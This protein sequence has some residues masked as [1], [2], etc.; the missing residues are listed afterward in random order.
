MK[1]T[2]V[3]KKFCAFLLILMWSCLW[4]ISSWAQILS[5]YHIDV[6]QGDATLIISPS[7]KT[8]L[9]D[10]GDTGK[11]ATRVFPLLQALKLD[12]IDYT[13]VTHYDSDHMGGMDEV[14]LA[15]QE[16]VKVNVF[17]RGGTKKSTKAI[18]EYQQMVEDHFKDKHQEIQPGMR[19]DLG[20]EI[21]VV[22]VAVNQ[23]IHSADSGQG[24]GD[25]ENAKSVALVIRYKDFD[26]FIGGDLTG[27][28]KSGSKRTPDMESQVARIVGDID[29]LKINHHGSQTSSNQFF[30]NVL[31]P[32]VAIISVGD[33]GKNRLYHHPH[34]LVLTRLRKLDTLEHIFMTHRGQT[35]GGL[36]KEE[37]KS[38]NIAN[39]NVVVTTNGKSYEVNGVVF[40][41]DGLH[42]LAGGN[43]NGE[44]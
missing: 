5:I 8:L 16:D 12:S 23:K 9:I 17:D 33:G 21:A 36:R 38:I 41:T 24:N 4:A 29:V 15:L 30:L 3:Y 39:G 25:D 19:I 37:L 26:Y 43:S 44:R 22:C 27:G 32:E 18:T 35:T 31:R 2:I 20:P 7:G 40:Q 10:A 42:S 14:L 1:S 13:L 28:G 6:D 11:G 34:R